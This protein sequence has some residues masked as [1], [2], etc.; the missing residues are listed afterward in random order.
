MQAEILKYPCVVELF[1]HGWLKCIK[2]AS[3]NVILQLVSCLHCAVELALPK[4]EVIAAD[5]CWMLL[6]WLRLYGL[7]KI[8]YSCRMDNFEGIN[9]AK[10]QKQKKICNA[11]WCRWA[12]LNLKC[13]SWNIPLHTCFTVLSLYWGLGDGQWSP[14]RAVLLLQSTTALP[15]FNLTWFCS[16][17]GCCVNP[18][19]FFPINEYYYIDDAMLSMCNLC[20]YDAS[21]IFVLNISKTLHI[22]YVVKNIFIV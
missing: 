5:I 13:A 7:H 9:R 15:Q 19:N 8:Q 4:R 22:V 18:S 17:K 1:K 16:G 6:Q 2:W 21:S 12:W 10:S 14:S 11:I 20:T 3:R